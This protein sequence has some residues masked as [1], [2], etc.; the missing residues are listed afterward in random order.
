MARVDPEVFG[1]KELVTVFLG[2]TVSE[3][4]RAES[5]LTDLGID[6]VVKPEPFGRSLLGSPRV[7]AIFYVPVD[8]AERCSAELV[9]AG[10]AR[11]VIMD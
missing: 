5:L 9:A 11:G 8:Q 7:G 10:L 4:R 1:D 2:A 3:A 6:Y